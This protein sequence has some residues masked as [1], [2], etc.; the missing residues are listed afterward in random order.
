MFLD[1]VFTGA[2]G[3]L[4]T[5]GYTTLVVGD[6]VGCD[7]KLLSEMAALSLFDSVRDISEFLSFSSMVVGCVLWTSLI[8]FSLSTIFLISA[9]G[10][11]FLT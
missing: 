1:A 4:S 2:A 5:S 7:D 3:R 10:M 11:F 9:T 6:V 8:C